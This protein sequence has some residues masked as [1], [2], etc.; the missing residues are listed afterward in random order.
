VEIKLYPDP[1]LSEL[2]PL[3]DMPSQDELHEFHQFYN[4]IP[5][6]IGLAAPQVGIRNRYFLFDGYFA[7]NPVVIQWG[8][9]MIDGYESCLSIP[10]F[11]I[12][13]SRSKKIKVVFTDPDGVR[14]T[15]QLVRR[16]A[17]VFQHEL[18]HLNGVLLND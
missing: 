15:R 5:N 18:D 11:K 8:D 4:S 7:F 12:K 6:A 3:G 10:G 1:I 16:E 14:V 17:V 13:K 9:I 2:M